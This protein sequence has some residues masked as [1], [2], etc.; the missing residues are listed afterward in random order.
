MR[1]AYADFD[2]AKVVAA[3]ASFMN[4]DLSAFYF[5]IRKDALYCDAPSSELRRE[6]LDVVE[7]IFRYVTVWLA[8]ILVFTCE[9]CWTSRDPSAGSVHLEQFPTAPAEWR[10]DALAKRWDA[11]RAP[12]RSSP[13][14]WRRRARR[15]RSARRSKRGR[16][17][18]SAIPN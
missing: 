8:P 10:D 12:A 3:L 6:A 15:R 5:D 13:A 14:R 2:Y 1:K 4:V 9:E 16:S 17:S 11:I 7:R 18:T